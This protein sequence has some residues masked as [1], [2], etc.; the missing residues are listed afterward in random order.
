MILFVS[1]QSAIR[2]PHEAQSFCCTLDSVCHLFKAIN[3]NNSLFTF[4]LFFF[5]VVI[6]PLVH[7][8][9]LEPVLIVL[10]FFLLFYYSAHSNK[11]F[12]SPPLYPN[13]FVKVT[14]DFC[15]DKFFK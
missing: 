4:L 6:V 15:F 14:Y 10:I 9:I 5:S 13:N 12:Y 3:F 1:S 11:A 2:S 7:F 8:F